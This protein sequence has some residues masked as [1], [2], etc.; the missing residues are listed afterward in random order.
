MWWLLSKPPR[1]ALSDWPAFEG[2]AKREHGT[3]SGKQPTKVGKRSIKDGK[4]IKAMVLVGVLV[5]CLIGS[6]WA[7]PAWWRRSTQTANQE[8][9]YPCRWLRHLASC[10]QSCPQQV[11]AV[12]SHAKT[13]TTKRGLWRCREGPRQLQETTTSG[14][15]QSYLLLLLFHHGIWLP[16]GIDPSP[17]GREPPYECTIT[18]QPEMSAI[19]QIASQSQRLSKVRSD[20]G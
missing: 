18:S 14:T 20:F 15:K 3:K 6:F 16:K 8:V 10:V 5:S 7:C 4:S 1:Q 19:F 17:Q 11:A 12:L 9:Y 2:I 13:R